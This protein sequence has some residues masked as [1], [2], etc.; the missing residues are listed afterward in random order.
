[1]KFISKRGS[2]EKKTG[3]DTM[4][5]NDNFTGFE[6]AHDE[7]VFVQDNYIEDTHN[8]DV[9]N[10][11]AE[12]TYNPESE[13]QYYQPEPE[14]YQ[15]E[16][17]PQYYQPEPE[18]QITENVPY[19]NQ[20]PTAEQIARAHAEEKTLY[21]ESS[22][23]ARQIEAIQNVIR[24]SEHV[25]G[26]IGFESINGADDEKEQDLDVPSGAWR[27]VKITFL[28]LLIIAGI[29]AGGYFGWQWWWTTHAT[30]DYEVQPVVILEGQSV[31]ANDFLED[32]YR[33]EGIEAEFHEFVI[34][35]NL[36]LQFVPLRLTH[37]M[38]TVETSAPLYTLI[39]VEYVEHEVGVEGTM[40]RPI[41]FIDNLEVAARVTFDIY[42]TVEPLPLESYPTGDHTLHLA[43]NSVPFE[44][45]LRVVDTTPP[46][47]TAEDRQI[48]VGEEIFPED[49]IIE[50]YDASPIHSI[51]FVEPPNF[52]YRDIQAVQIAVEDI[53]GNVGFVVVNLTIVFN[54]APP[55]LFGV[56]EIIEAQ[57]GTEIDFLYGITAHDDL[58]R[59]LDVHVDSVDVDINTEGVYI[60]FIWAE[61]SSGQ[62][63]QYEVEVHMH[64]FDPAEL[65]QR[66]DEILDRIL[67]T[68]MSQQE[69]A[70]AIHNWVRQNLSREASSTETQ[71]VLAGAYRAL[72]NRRGDSLIYSAISSLM[73]TRAGVPNMLIERTADAD[74][75]HRWVLINPD[76][77]GW[78]HF[79]PFPTGLALGNSTAM[80]TNEQA[81]EF[82]RRIYANGGAADYFTFDEGAFPDVVQEESDEDEDDDEDD[83]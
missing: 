1:M 54:Q 35:P 61:D 48:N 11:V 3:R 38:R 33:V 50:I 78:H 79:D 34:E 57:V 69:Q 14:H 62:T 46:V 77:L 51:S 26:Q 45:I 5:V 52:Y 42:F 7:G 12:T 6:G 60:A 4:P 41:D 13:P 64:N 56:P 21:P 24:P 63:T 81:Q 27:A 25:P 68:G 22:L 36:G 76:N 72:E 40:L 30:F 53:Y 9:Y 66:V 43:L 28:V 74:T 73:L 44:A 19:T 18:P 37:G 71:S 65:H 83:D 29:G 23:S 70:V 82:A 75:S 49:F 58:G 47:I 15:S 59:V 39:P 55:M 17:E 20:P 67:S 8:Q 10:S 16:P 2:R 80:F 32:S 31:I